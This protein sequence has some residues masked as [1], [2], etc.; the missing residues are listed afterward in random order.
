MSQQRMPG[1]ITLS[2]GH[3]LLHAG[4]MPHRVRSGQS[5]LMSLEYKDGSEQYRGPWERQSAKYPPPTQSMFHWHP[6]MGQLTQS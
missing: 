6:K 4:R 3:P 5:A 2:G 1:S